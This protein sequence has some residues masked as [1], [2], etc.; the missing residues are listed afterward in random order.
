[1][2]AESGPGGT[3]TIAWVDGGGGGLPCHPHD[4]TVS[5]RTTQ[6]SPADRMLRWT[7]YGAP[8]P[9]L[10]TGP[11]LACCKKGIGRGPNQQP[12]SALQGALRRGDAA[13]AEW[14]L[15]RCPSCVPTDLAGRRALTRAVLCGG[16]SA[17]ATATVWCAPPPAGSGNNMLAKCVDRGPAALGFAALR[18]LSVAGPEGDNAWRTNWCAACVLLLG[19]PAVGSDMVVGEAVL[20]GAMCVA[21][22]CV[23]RAMLSSAAAIDTE[24]F[25]G[26]RAACS[27]DR[28]AWTAHAV[29]A[30]RRSPGLDPA[31]EGLRLVC[32]AAALHVAGEGAWQQAVVAL[33]A[34]YQGGGISFGQRPV[35]R[36]PWTALG[37]AL[38]CAGANAAVTVA[39]LLED[40]ALRM[41][42]PDVASDPSGA[43]ALAL[44]IVTA[45]CG[46]RA[47]RLLRCLCT[48]CRPMC[49]G[50]SVHPLGRQPVSGGR[51]TVRK[52]IRR[53]CRSPRARCAG[54]T[55]PSCAGC[56]AIRA[57]WPE[58]APP[59]RYVTAPACAPR[60]PA[61]RACSSTPCLRT[62]RTTSARGSAR[63]S[64]EEKSEVREN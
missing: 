43:A 16:P 35:L 9:Q 60:W 55:Q 17:I 61:T 8:A 54:T 21:P 18:V 52:S 34:R 30:L 5:R 32:G 3:P 31:A 59:P 47:H 10:G 41:H 38:R 15:A 44:D 26:V 7:G 51:G 58:A 63:L 49:T 42:A 12:V 50:F 23:L 14:L 37:G 33:G 6:R 62:T 57:W 20:A 36:L 19:R 48:V 13:G 45:G 2:F 40:D 64:S 1:M 29:R 39:V 28:R 25:A 53:P 24:D 56:A 22:P 11:R 46:E 27:Q 4:R